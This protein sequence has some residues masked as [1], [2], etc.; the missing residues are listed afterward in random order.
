MISTNDLE[1]DTF[2]R[3]YR[4]FGRSANQTSYNVVQNGFKFYM[5]NLNAT[6]GLISLK[7]YQRNLESRKRN[8]E[9]IK[10][11]VK[12]DKVIKHDKKS[13]YYFATMFCDNAD[14]K[15]KKMSITRHYPL[16]HKTKYFENEYRGKLNNIEDLFDK[17]INV[18]IHENLTYENTREIIRIVNE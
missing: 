18:P 10:N 17:F 9:I 5:N 16:L 3:L 4:N 15:L 8:F 1:A 7:K 14:L 13:S 12:V 11:H 2:F 6:L